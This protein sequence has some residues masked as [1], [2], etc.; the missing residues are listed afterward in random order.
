MVARFA[1]ALLLAAP[2]FAG[3]CCSGLE[4]Q[5]RA[6]WLRLE[7]LK[8]CPA[9]ADDEPGPTLSDEATGA[10]IFRSIPVGGSADF[11][12]TMPTPAGVGGA[13]Y[14][15][16][17]LANDGTSDGAAEMSLQNVQ[18]QAHVAQGHSTFQVTL[19]AKNTL[20]SVHTVKFWVGNASDIG[21]TAYKVRINP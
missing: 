2:L 17:Y 4:E 8:D 14:L 7:Q 10:P 1:C 18:Y 16:A 13:T 21:N 9:H 6:L 11:D 20:T 3:G 19:H 15:I 5:N 12:F